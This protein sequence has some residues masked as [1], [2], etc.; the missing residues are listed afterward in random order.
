MDGTTIDAIMRGDK[1]TA[2]LFLGVYAADT[3]PRVLH[4][5]PSMLIANTDC[6]SKSGSHWIAVFIDENGNGEFFDSYGM[7]PIIKEHRQFLNR[8]CKKWKYNVKKLQAYNSS[9]CGEYC[10]LYLM[11]KAHGYSLKQF[12]RM[13]FDKNDRKNDAIVHY[14][15]KRYSKKRKF[16]HEFIVNPQTCTPRKIKRT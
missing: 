11:H 3:L 4:S 14:M 1:H 15:V 7:P 10:L 12:L 6:I 9:V 5:Y 2:P 13:Y 16:C 8:L